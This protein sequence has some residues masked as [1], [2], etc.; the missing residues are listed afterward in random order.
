M[1]LAE[2]IERTATRG[3]LVPGVAVLEEESEAILLSRPSFFT[4][5]KEDKFE[6]LVLS[7]SSDTYS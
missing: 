5:E 2:A 6:N 4:G 7:S 3:S 1:A